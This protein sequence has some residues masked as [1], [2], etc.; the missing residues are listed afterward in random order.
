MNL[1]KYL[2]VKK[3][4]AAFISVMKQ[5]TTNGRQWQGKKWKF[6]CHAL[7]WTMFDINYTFYRCR[8]TY[9]FSLSISH[10]CNLSL[11]LQ[12]SEETAWKFNKR[13]VCNI[14]RNK[15]KW[16]QLRFPKKKNF[17]LKFNRLETTFE[18]TSCSRD[19]D[20]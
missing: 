15:M 14:I 13:R 9:I 19:D 4:V 16:D 2:V 1:I 10:V 3:F 7:T 8:S 20:V 11:R 12:F 5:I 6:Y 18:S 17:T